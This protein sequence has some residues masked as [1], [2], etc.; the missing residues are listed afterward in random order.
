MWHTQFVKVA[1]RHGPV[2]RV[3]ASE[4]PPTYYRGATNN[5]GIGVGK[6]QFLV[7][8]K[9]SQII[10]GEPSDRQD[11]DRLHQQEVPRW[12]RLR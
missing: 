2:T 9:A 11:L 4:D 10:R 6:G 7:G 3:R 1:C 8:S 5:N 12:R